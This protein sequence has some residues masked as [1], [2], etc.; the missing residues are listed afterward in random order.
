MSLA[1][2]EELIALIEYVQWRGD[3]GYVCEPTCPW[4]DSAIGHQSCVCRTAPDRATHPIPAA[5]HCSD[6][7]A[8]LLMGWPRR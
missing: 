8:A 3:A 1:S 7:P 4:C 6:C 5:E 2:R